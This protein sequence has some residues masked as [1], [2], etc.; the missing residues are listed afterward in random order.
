MKNKKFKSIYW[1]LVVVIVV[2]IIYSSFNFFNCYILYFYR[3][4]KISK[5][6]KTNEFYLTYNGSKYNHLKWPQIIGEKFELKKLEFAYRDDFLN[7]FS[8]IF[9]YDINNL[10]DKFIKSS[11]MK[12]HNIEDFK[13]IASRTLV[14]LND[15][16]PSKIDTNDVIEGKEINKRGFIN[17]TNYLY[18][19]SFYYASKND[20]RTALLLAYLPVLLLQEI[21]SNN[22]DGGNPYIKMELMDMRNTACIN[23]LFL[24]NNTKIDKE[25]AI[26]I[27]KNLLELT[28]SEPS[29][30][31][32][33]EFVKKSI[34]H[35]FS[36][37]TISKYNGRLPVKYFIDNIY[38]SKEW[39][40][41]IDAIYDRANE[42]IKKLESGKNPQ[43][44]ESW[45]ENTQKFLVENN[46]FI[47][48]DFFYQSINWKRN[49]T[50]YVI[51]NFPETF[52][53]SFY[54]LY[55][56]R[57]EYLAITEGTAIALALAAYSSDKNENEDKIND[58]MPKNIN[59]LSK[60]LGVELPLDR[61]SK[62][63][64]Q[65][66]FADD[67]FLAGSPSE[68]KNKD[69]YF[70]NYLPYLKN[71]WVFNSQPSINGNPIPPINKAPLSDSM[72]KFEKLQKQMMAL[73]SLQKT[74]NSYGRSRINF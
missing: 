74:I 1:I 22:L 63:P 39:Q 32:Y 28:K 66:Y 19:A 46:S 2:Y 26:K 15:Y 33:L 60:W 70:Q 42:E 8:D 36:E 30:L 21:E 56:K 35:V 64:Y 23:L 37:N 44:L 54:D 72:S 34:K 47:E 3:L 68:E 20:N 25:I 49:I 62:S 31:R 13:D 71:R 4:S 73:E 18:S 57:E 5:A 58:S 6:L 41:Q 48:K 27:S 67:Y 55:K 45:Q 11:D 43:S 50:L 29:L 38:N 12:Y 51:A 59:E 52:Y 17:L 10:S 16:K 24:A 53:T 7:N 69:S 14:F 65:F 61:M 40:E 9:K